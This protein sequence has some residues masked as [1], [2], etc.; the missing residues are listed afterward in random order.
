MLLNIILKTELAKH[1]ICIINGFVYLFVWCYNFE[2]LR[3]LRSEI[4]EFTVGGA[5]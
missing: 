5:V 4:N 2:R 1:K 3:V